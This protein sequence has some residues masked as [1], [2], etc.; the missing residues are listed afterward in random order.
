MKMHIVQEISFI[1]YQVLC[2]VWLL[3]CIKCCSITPCDFALVMMLNISIV[4]SLH[5]LSH[6]IRGFA[7]SFV[8]VIQGL[9]TLCSESD[10]NKHYIATGVN[11]NQQQSQYEYKEPTKNQGEIHFADL[12]FAYSASRQILSN[13]SIIVPSQ[14]LGLVGYSGSGKTTFIHLILGLFEVSSGQ[15]LI[16]NQD[17]SQMSKEF[18]HNKIGI[19]PQDITLFNRT[20]MEKIRYRRIDATD[21]EVIE[22][23]KQSK[24]HVF[25]SNLLEQYDSLVG[26]R[27]ETLWWRTPENSNS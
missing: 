15:I 27:S 9:Q 17:I 24:A 11:E 19:I 23:A 25:I 6:N 5:S 4:N 26:E 16:D 20:L 7:E 14:K 2:F 3:Q 12:S 18:L 8:N 22:A 10:D 21:K 1:M 13:L